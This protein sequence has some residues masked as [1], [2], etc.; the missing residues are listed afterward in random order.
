MPM[1]RSYPPPTLE[2]A[3]D[4]RGSPYE[5]AFKKCDYPYSPLLPPLEKGEA[6]KPEGALGSRR[7]GGQYR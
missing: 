1:A 5:G 6:P 4:F 2:D 7:R 3:D